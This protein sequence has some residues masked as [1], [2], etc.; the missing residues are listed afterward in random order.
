MKEYEGSDPPLVRPDSELAYAVRSAA[1]TLE[2][3]LG[4]ASAAGLSVTLTV[5]EVTKLGKN[6]PSLMLTI[7][8]AL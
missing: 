8:R 3:A 5:V 1:R 4:N 7:T 2:E 6:I